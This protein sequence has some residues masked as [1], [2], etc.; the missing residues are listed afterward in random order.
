MSFFRFFELPRELRDLIYEEYV[1]IDGGYVF[2]LACWKLRDVSKPK[3]A[4]GLQRT[5]KAVHAEMEGL[6]LRHNTI[7]FSTQL[8]RWEGMRALRLEK[9]L[10]NGH[11]TVFDGQI[12]KLWS[13]RDRIEDSVREDV[14]RRYP[15]FLPH[16]DWLRGPHNPD[17]DLGY[18]DRYKIYDHLGERP[19]LF[20][21]YV[22]HVL[23]SFPPGDY[24][25]KLWII[26]SDASIYKTA[27]G[28]E[29]LYRLKAGREIRDMLE[30]W[31]CMGNGWSR[32]RFSA[33]AY[34]IAFL[35][36]YPSFRQHMRK[37]VLNEDFASVAHPE[38]HGQG[39]IRFCAEN[40]RLRIERHVDVFDTVFPNLE[41]RYYT[42]S[43]RRFPV[44]AD[45]TG[46]IGV[47]ISEALALPPTISLVFVG[48]N[49]PM[50]CKHIFSTRIV[51]EARCRDALEEACARGILSPPGPME[52][53]P[54]L[55]PA[56][57]GPKGG[58]FF[59]GV[60]K[61]I[62]N[63]VENKNSETGRVRCDFDPGSSWDVEDVIKGRYS[64]SS[65]EWLNS[66]NWSAFNDLRGSRTILSP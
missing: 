39:L 13:L 6:A 63:M 46:K 35:D 5:C 50:D 59:K 27:L 51:R 61:A 47:W 66:G 15:C 1:F 30:H 17:V 31:R 23:E 10:C 11:I 43:V 18:D 37:I 4:F 21:E 62:W 52:R 26:P 32:Y 54:L 65:D 56:F 3:H 29:S 58:C 7:T 34:A 16:L 20:R 49:Y 33:A 42:P 28:L 38:C 44:P 41:S 64:W 12:R 40:S 25:E 57:P 45:P 22:C 9:V 24:I 8:N 48:G 53:F 60:A 36:R 55:S 19:S 2:N 14:A